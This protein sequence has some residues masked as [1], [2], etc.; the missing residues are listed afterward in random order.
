[1]NDRHLLIGAAC[2][3]NANRDLLQF[4][5]MV[6]MQKSDPTDNSYFEYR[7]TVFQIS[8]GPEFNMCPCSLFM[9]EGDKPST[10]WEKTHAIDEGVILRDDTLNMMHLKVGISPS[11]VQPQGFNSGFSQQIA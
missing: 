3:G 8:H 1:M 5:V 10:A 6:S 2:K 4:M 9:L 11:V 7:V